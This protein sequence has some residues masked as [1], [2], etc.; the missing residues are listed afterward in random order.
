MC[1]HASVRGPAAVA[2]ALA[3]SRGARRVSLAPAVAI[4]SARGMSGAGRRFPYPF[5]SAARMA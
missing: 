2:G 5:G 1:A 3:A 4:G